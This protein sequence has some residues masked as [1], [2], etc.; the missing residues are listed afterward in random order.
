MKSNDITLN[1]FSDK[2]GIP[3]FKNIIIDDK[4]FAR[5]SIDVQYQ[6]FPYAQ[7][8]PLSIGTNFTGLVAGVKWNQRI[9]DITPIKNNIFKYYVS[10]EYKW[11]FLGINIYTQSKRF[12]G[13]IVLD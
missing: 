12:E 5:L 8:V 1:H 13:K 6:E 3:D 4:E 2:A 10:G 7:N 9:I 11:S